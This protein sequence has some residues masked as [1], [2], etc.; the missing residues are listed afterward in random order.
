MNMA[1]ELFRDPTEGSKPE[2]SDIDWLLN[3]GITIDAIASPWA[4]H[5]ARVVFDDR[6]GFLPCPGV[7]GFAFVFAVIDCGTIIDA[8]AWQPKSGKIA[9][10]LGFGAML[11][12]G[13][14]GRDEIGTTGR[15]LPVWRDPVEWLKAGRCGV[16][17]ADPVLAAHR[18]AGIVISGEDHKH[19]RELRKGLRLP[20][21][22]IVSP[23]GNSNSYL[24]AAA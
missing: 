14:I 9:T 21:P 17:I 12:E 13:Q 6:G 24:G 20:S 1:L 11:G 19:G 22:M 5:A 7:G 8:A 23:H 18:L 3:Q 2:Q 10:R 4:V 15:P 16:V